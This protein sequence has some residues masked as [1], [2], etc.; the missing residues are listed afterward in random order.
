MYQTNLLQKAFADKGFHYSKDLIYNY[1]DLRFFTIITKCKLK[2][3]FTV[4]LRNKEVK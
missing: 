4:P 3:I 1:F 2:S